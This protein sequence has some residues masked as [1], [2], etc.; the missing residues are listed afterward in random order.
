MD[1]KNITNERRKEKFKSEMLSFRVSPKAKKFIEDNDYS[2]SLIFIEA[3]R[4][5]GF[6]E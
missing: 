2:P 3:L 6:E 5:L 1:K 4:D